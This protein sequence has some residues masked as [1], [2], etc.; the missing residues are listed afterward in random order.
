MKRDLYER[1]GVQEYWLVDPD[2]D[3]LEIYRRSGDTFGAPDRYA[4][5]DVVTTPLLPGL[6]LPLNKI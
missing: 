2:H 5:D 6:E 4:K 3:V 1:V